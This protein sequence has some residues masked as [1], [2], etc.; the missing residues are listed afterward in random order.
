MAD[1]KGFI[2]TMLVF[3][4]IMIGAW[5]F[6]SD[7]G[8]TFSGSAAGNVTDFST[9]SQMQDVND[10]ITNMTEVYRTKMTTQTTVTDIIFTQIT[11]FIDFIDLAGTILFG[12][13]NDL[14]KGISDAFNIPVWFSTMI[15]AIIMIIILLTII[16]AIVKWVL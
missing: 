2:I 13:W 6:V 10:K 3:S 12:T 1:I 14:M 4:G 5:A 11:G 9:L 8:R 16:S 7:L 15:T